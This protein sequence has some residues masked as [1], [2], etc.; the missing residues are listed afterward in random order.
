MVWKHCWSLLSFLDPW[1]ASAYICSKWITAYPI[2]AVPQFCP[3][4]YYN[5]IFPHLPFLLHCPYLHQGEEF[6][7][8]LL[9]RIFFSLVK[10]NSKNIIKL[11]CELIFN[12]IVYYLTFLSTSDSCEHNTVEISIKRIDLLSILRGSFETVQK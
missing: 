5:L 7:H 2:T 11:Y 4:L 8:R 10:H 3:E 6:A 9:R 1:H 12:R